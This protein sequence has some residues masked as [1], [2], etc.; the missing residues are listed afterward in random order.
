MKKTCYVLLFVLA[1]VMG[2]CFAVLCLTDYLH[3]YPF[4][5]APFYVYVLMRGLEFLLPALLFLAQALWLRKAVKR[6]GGQG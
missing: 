1:A 6:E 2:V 5:S 4:G 3:L